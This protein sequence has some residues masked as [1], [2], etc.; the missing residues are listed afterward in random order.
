MYKRQSL[1]GETIETFDITDH[2]VDN[3]TGDGSET[4]FTLSGTVPNNNS[5]VVTI[6]GVV[7]HSSDATTA[8]S[9]SIVGS[10]LVFTSAPALGDE[11][12][13][14]HIGFAGSTTGGVTGF[15]GRTGNVVL[16]A[17]D[18]ITTGDITARNINS[19]GIITATS[20]V[21]SGANL[22]GIDATAVKD[23][24]GNVKIQAQASGAV[25]LS[26]IHI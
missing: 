13:V 3:F 7:Q 10:I 20:F 11:I 15:Y 23:S 18:H 21:G 17:S 16:A 2:R 26:L 1:I 25:Y 12:Q 24:G 22:T 6:N 19:S 4:E 8:R 9:Y 5:V 14:K